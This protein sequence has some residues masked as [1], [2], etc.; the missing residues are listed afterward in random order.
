MALCGNHRKS[1][2]GLSHAPHVPAMDTMTALERTFQLARSGQVS[3]LPAIV[4]ALRG[5]GYSAN[6]LQG[7]AQGDSCRYD[8]S[9]AREGFDHPSDLDAFRQ[10][11]RVPQ[12]WAL[13]SPWR[14][15]L[16]EQSDALRRRSVIH[17]A[18]HDHG[19][20]R[21]IVDEMKA[22]MI[23]NGSV[24]AKRSSRCAVVTTACDFNDTADALPV[25][26]SR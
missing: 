7:P 20:T 13:C 17:A 19:H 23:S 15:P 24:V 25:R 2:Q 16:T 3:G 21:G 14:L 9:C 8:Q 10:P 6:R 22:E 5:E 26:S 11:G 4:E 18:D 12:S 1:T